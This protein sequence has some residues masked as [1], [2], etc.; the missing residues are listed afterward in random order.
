[1]HL[2][3]Q[4]DEVRTIVG[5]GSLCLCDS[6]LG[7]RAEAAVEWKGSCIAR[8]LETEVYRNSLKH[9]GELVA[10][11]SL[12]EYLPKA[13]TLF[14]TPKTSLDLPLEKAPAFESRNPDDWISAKKCGAV[15][16][17]VADDAAA[18]Q[19]AIDSGK[20]IVYLPRG[21]YRISKTIELRGALRRLVGMG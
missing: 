17:G 3:G 9:D 11:P 14:P 6:Y 21:T 4:Q 10:E 13:S 15:G 1:R 18:I 5:D 7:G 19:R 8:R 12:D 16:D 2:T 20:P